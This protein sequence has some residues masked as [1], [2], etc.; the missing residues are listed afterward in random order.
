MKEEIKLKKK[1]IKNSP[2]RE[3]IKEEMYKEI[4]ILELKEEQC[5]YYSEREL[6]FMF[7]LIKGSIQLKLSG[8][9]GIDINFGIFDEFVPIGEGEL[10]NENGTRLDMYSLKDETT[11][12]QI[13]KN[14]VLKL[15]KDDKF[16]IFMLEHQNKKLFKALERLG[17]QKYLGVTKYVAFSILEYSK[18]SILRFKNMTV[19]CR[20]LN[21]DRKSLYTS[22]KILE[23]KNYIIRKNKEIMIINKEE[24]EKYIQF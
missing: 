23:G 22:I 18:S 4:N 9:D 12:I 24:L 3:Y 11:V 16:R 5:L 20:L 21:I 2:L 19:F 17:V 13:P 15:L 14:M 8:H 1:I 10:F 7:F 6:N